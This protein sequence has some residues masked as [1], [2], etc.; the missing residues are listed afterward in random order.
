MRTTL[1]IDDELARQLKRRAA[2][3]GRSFKE[4]VNETLKAGLEQAG[5]APASRP[6]RLAP[7]AMG[8]PATGLDLD[9][10]LQLAG[11]LEDEELARKLELRK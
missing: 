7:V 2:E 6:Y 3:S 11:N 10:A 4:V 5:S 1:T 9:K 8:R